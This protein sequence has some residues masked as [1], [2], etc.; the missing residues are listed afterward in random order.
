MKTVALWFLLNWVGSVDSPIIWS[1]PMPT[2][3]ECN[4]VRDVVA[5]QWGREHDRYRHL[6]CVQIITVDQSK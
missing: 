6:T 5:T 4:R 2:K 3:E 1:P